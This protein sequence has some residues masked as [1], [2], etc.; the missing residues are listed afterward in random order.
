MSLLTRLISPQVGEIKLPVHQ[1][2][3]ALAEYK[4]GSITDSQIISTFNL[5]ASEAI[6]LQS[7]LDNMDD[8]SI[9]RS[10][11]HDVLMLGE[12]GYYDINK[13]KSEL[14]I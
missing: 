7:F 1:F 14:G 9:D 2:M 10:K 11:L 8:D 13:V 4:R 6:S 5:N 3:S 12:S